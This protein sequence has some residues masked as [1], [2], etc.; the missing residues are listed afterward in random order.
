M[1]PLTAARVCQPAVRTLQVILAMSLAPAVVAALQHQPDTVMEARRF[2]RAQ[3]MGGVARLDVTSLNAA[4]AAQGYPTLPR[5]VITYGGGAHLIAG[6]L[7]VGGSGHSILSRTETNPSFT[8]K[9]S[10]GYGLLDVGAVVV[11]AR[12]TTVF[13]VAGGGAGRLVSRIQAPGGF[14]F[15]GALTSPQRGVE[16]RAHTYLYHVGVGI[17]Q[18]AILSPSGPHVNLGVRAGYIGR[19]GDTKWRTIDGDVTAAPN[20][21]FTGAYVRVT[22]GRGLKHRVEAVIPAAAPVVPWLLR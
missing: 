6:R 19:A 18:F 13:V 22:V 10:G 21:A 20:A 4:L 16:L 15:A 9:L 2:G 8:N 12:R 17:D 3:F 1:K 11:T 7:I 14:T 5:T